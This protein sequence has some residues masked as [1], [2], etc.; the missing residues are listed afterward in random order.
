MNWILGRI[1]WIMLVSGVLTCTMVY[2]AIAPQAALRS[3]F[4]ETLDGAVA[5]IV[6]RNWGALI[7]L[8]GAMLIYGAYDPPSRPLIV[9]VAGLSKLTFIALVLLHGRQYLGH[10]VGIS[11]AVDLVMVVLFIAFLIGVRR[12]RAGAS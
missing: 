10:Q 12:G 1:K 6:V 8:V 7:A 9:T 2:A 4:G 5:E 3:T 11:I